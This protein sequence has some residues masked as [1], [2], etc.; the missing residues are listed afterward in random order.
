V[1]NVSLRSK[2]LASVGAFGVSACHLGVSRYLVR[3]ATDARLTWGG[4]QR[5]Q[6]Q[7]DAA[8]REFEQKARRKKLEAQLTRPRKK[9]SKAQRRRNRKR[10]LAA[11]GNPK[12]IH[13]GNFKRPEYYGYINS[14]AWRARRKQYFERHGEQCEVCGSTDRVQLHH[15]NYISLGREKDR[16]L[17]A[18][19]EG[20]H[21][22]EHEPDGVADPITREFLSLNL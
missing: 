11:D 12:P 13:G 16:D 4:N 6:A 1:R 14:K 15:K 2:A 19:C 5:A 7:A 9:L 20:C 8:W 22:N 3:M 18:L 17:Q 10:G 21:Q